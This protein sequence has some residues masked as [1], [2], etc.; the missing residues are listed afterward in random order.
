MTARALSGTTGTYASGGTNIRHMAFITSMVVSFALAKGPTTVAIEAK[1]ACRL[2]SLPGTEASVRQFK[3]KR[4]LRLGGQGIAVE[5][6]LGKPA[7]SLS[8]HLLL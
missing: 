7:A 2:G 1:S 5:E 8:T 6:F 4:R 3:P